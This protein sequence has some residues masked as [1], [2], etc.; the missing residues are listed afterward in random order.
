MATII[1]RARA[2][3]LD[4]G[5]VSL[6]GIAASM[7]DPVLVAALR[8][9][10]VLYAEVYSW[11]I[12]DEPEPV[13]R[14]EVSQDVLDRA[15]T[16]ARTFNDLFTDG[17]VLPGEDSAPA[18]WDAY[19]GNDIHGRCVRIARDP[20]RSTGPNYHWGVYRD[21]S[22][23]YHVEDFWDERL[24]TTSYYSGHRVFPVHG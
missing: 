21:P 14:W 5:S 2:I 16:F 9:T 13:Y 24:W 7:G 17:L 20:G 12:S 6:V 3:A 19:V 10:V 8:E 4:S 15:A 11:S 1:E 22:G 18:Y 23:E